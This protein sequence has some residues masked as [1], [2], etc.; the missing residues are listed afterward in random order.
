MRKIFI[1]LDK[2]HLSVPNLI[3]Y[4]ASI[5][6]ISTVMFQRMYMMLT[7]FTVWILYINLKIYYNNFEL[8]PKLSRQ[9]VLVTVLGFLTQYNFCFYVGFLS[10]V[11]IC[12]ALVKK[13]KSK[14]GK[15][16]FQYV[17]SAIIG[18][19]L[20]LP[21]I[22]HIFFSYR[23]GGRQPREF[24]NFEAFK[25]FCEN[26]FN[27]YSLSLKVGAILSI[28]LLII[29]IWKF[30]NSKSKGIYT[31]L[32]IPTILTFFMMIFMSPYK[33]LRYVM[34]LLPII[35]MVVVILLDEFIE[36]KKF[37]S[38]I[39]TIFS[40]YLSIYGIF[41]NPINYLYIGYQKY[42]D[43]AEEYKDDRFVLVSNTIF[44][45]IQDVPEFKIYKESLIIEPDNLE[46]M[47]Q[48][49]EFEDEDEFILGIKNWINKSRDDILEEVMKSTGFDNYELLYS[50]T[51]S[52][53]LDV[54]RFY[55]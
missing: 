26:V 46:D 14:I 18:V 3:L 23:G 47:E 4:G 55:K 53:R 48:F 2:K 44:S 24:T 21:S 41:N 7:F 8:T 20:F 10:I 11:M 31:I 28:V 39:L 32:V 27:S 52:A 45:H 19:L 51:K 22:Y 15:Y 16:I 42:L 37:S 49:T 13:E 17:K 6:A 34:Y 35:S 40:I 36:N 50:S 30:L 12:L 54:Y 1:L 25:A 38:T 9:L 29:F 33:S 43:I 5:G